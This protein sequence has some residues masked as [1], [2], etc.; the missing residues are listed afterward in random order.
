MLLN[1]KNIIGYTVGNQEYCLKCYTKNVEEQDFVSPITIDDMHEEQ[2]F[3]C[4][5]CHCYIGKK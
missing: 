2:K 3:T 1:S 4:G 5:E